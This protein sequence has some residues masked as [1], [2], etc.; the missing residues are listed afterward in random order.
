MLESVQNSLCQFIYRYLAAKDNSDLK[1]TKTIKTETSS[2]EPGTSYCSSIMKMS[3]DVDNLNP[4]HK[5][6]LLISLV[7]DLHDCVDIMQNRSYLD[8][9]GELKP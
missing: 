2:A 7:D 5:T 4:A 3:E 6:S 9:S 1:Y 8:L